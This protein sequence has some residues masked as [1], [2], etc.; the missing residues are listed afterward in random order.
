MLPALGAAPPFWT[1]GAKE[2]GIDAFHHLVYAGA[3]YAL[4]DRWN[5]RPAIFVKGVG[6]GPRPPNPAEPVWPDTLCVAADRGTRA[7]PGATRN[8]RLQEAGR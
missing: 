8:P 6:A 7:G 4:L 1:W 2:V 3:A 5:R